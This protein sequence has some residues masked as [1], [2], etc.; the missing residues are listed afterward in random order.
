MDFDFFLRLSKLKDIP[1]VN[2][3]LADFRLQQEA[4]TTNGLVNFRKEHI[5]VARKHNASFFSKGILSDYYVIIT[6]PIRNIPCIRNLFRKLKGLE[7]YDEQ[8]FN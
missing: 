7:K 1:Y 8:K 3:S 2:R 5:K 6:E 4:K